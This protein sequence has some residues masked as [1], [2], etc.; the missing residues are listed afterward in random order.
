MTNKSSP[1]LASQDP[2]SS[3]TVSSSSGWSNGSTSG[4]GQAKSAYQSLGPVLAT[5]NVNRGSQTFNNS[6]R[7]TALAS[8][9]IGSPATNSFNKSSLDSFLSPTNTQ[10]KSTMGQTRPAVSN[11][12]GGS[13]TQPMS[14]A[15]NVQMNKTGMM[16]NMQMNQTRMAGN[17][18]MGQQGMMGN[19]NQQRMSGMQMSQQGMMGGMQMSQPSMGN[20]Q[21][22]QPRM[23]SMTM[24]PQNTIGNMQMSQGMMGNRPMGQP[25]GGANVMGG[26][27]GG[28]LQPPR[29]QHPMM[30]NQQNTKSL[31]SQDI[32]DFL[33][34]YRNM[35]RVLVIGTVFGYL[36]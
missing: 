5:S 24:N 23:G 13:A 12:G 25:F 4:G 29:T 27:G 8:G 1:L 35:S 2:F 9:G 32:A 7:G 16:G 21:M 17:M 3:P 10:S 19:M 26:M 36:W 30:N 34:W 33:G 11:V 18:P 28:M 31:S 22:G 6:P 14:M 20:M 15:G